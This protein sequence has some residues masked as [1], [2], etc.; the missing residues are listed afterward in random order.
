[1][2]FES[3]GSNLT[4]RGS[5]LQHSYGHFTFSR[6]PS[7]KVA[8]ATRAF[9]A[10]LLLLAR[11]YELVLEGNRDTS[12]EQLTKAYRKVALKAHPDKGGRKEDAQTLPDRLTTRL[13][14]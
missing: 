7:S 8:V 5:G 6:T 4:C 9:V 14:G 13:T 1:M 10:V 3:P 11:R 12:V 2:C